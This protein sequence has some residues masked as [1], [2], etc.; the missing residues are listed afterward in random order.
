M[1]YYPQDTPSMNNIYESNYTDYVK[2]DEYKRSDELYKKS[3]QPYS[4]GVVPLPAYSTMFQNINNNELDN[5][6]ISSLTGEKVDVKNF[7]HN[8]MQP[9][10]KGNVTQ[11]TNIEKYTQKLDIDTG[12]D[13]L[14]MKKQEIESIFKPTAGYH[15][16]NGTKQYTDYFQSR[17]EAPKIANNTTP[18]EKI[19]VGPGLNKGY[20]NQG[21]GGFQQLESLDYARPKNL[22]QLR[23]KIDQRNTFFEIPI[24]AP[25]KGTEQRGVVAPYKKNKP[26][27]TYKQ[28]E[29]NWLRTTASVL[30][31]TNRP[32]M[33]VKT[34]TRPELHVSY[35]GQAKLQDIKGIGIDD[36]YGKSKI[37]I[38]DN[39]RQET[40]TRTTV[41]N[42]TS[43][44]KAIISP[45]LDALKYSN[46][47]FLVE[48]TRAGGNP[49][50]Q[51]PNKSTVYNP[52]DP[53]KTTVK[54]TTIHDSENLNLS[55][56]DKGYS[57]IQDNAKT[58]V[59]ETTIHDSENL[60]LSGSD[61]A[62]SAIQ[63]NAKKTVKETTVYDS[64][65]LNLNGSDKGYSAIQDD[66]KT[67]VKETIIH[68]S[69]N[70]N[71]SGADKSY[72]AIQDDAKTTVKETTIQDM[73]VLN[74]KGKGCSTYTK[75]EDKAKTTTKE[76]LP[77][78][79]SVRNI[80]SGTYRVYTYDPDKMK[81]KKT[82][83]ETTIR[84]SSSDFG[85]ISGVIN[86]ILGGYATKEIDLKVTNKQFTS[87]NEE[88]GVA[89]S[90]YEHRQRSREAEEN[91]E[92]D[93]A[94]ERMMIQAGH[95]PNP[96]GMNIPIDKEDV[97]MKTNKLITDSYS[98]RESGNVEII[99][100]KGP[101]IDNCGITKDNQTNNNAYENRLDG[102][103]LE[104]L[105][106]NDFNIG[107]NPI[108]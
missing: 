19:H 74:I 100:Q 49:A 81:M 51:I 17:V 86:S 99:Y 59:K 42:I 72:S 68:D 4:S 6:F 105:K 1:D 82:V 58:T 25:P 87:D 27:R 50:A 88:Y 108:I 39:E 97:N 45:V 92:I 106:S 22:D 47:E 46:K 35:T 89:K 10:L 33:T 107:I 11:N 69:E 14:Y 24:Q 2:Q 40:E 13:K 31:E 80:G 75:S 43:I 91:A 26:E 54:E 62:Y 101:E 77:V 66:A 12:V 90:V 95:T 57:A 94:R 85:F 34:T 103:I 98:Q 53:L 84:G 56:S 78:Q 71:L 61:K 93:G 15:N 18:F 8:N 79:D 21:T 20:T 32:K 52:D 7:K 104:S 29:D 73:D 60:N 65:N 3:K 5:Q 44:V 37:I 48:A 16:I 63:D 38:Y 36:D 67:T 30:K 96:G 70:L 28:T 23:S 9:F 41:S 76:T 102:S 64:E 55:G 83:K